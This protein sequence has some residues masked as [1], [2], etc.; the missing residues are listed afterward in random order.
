MKGSRHLALI[1][2]LLVVPTFAG[3]AAPMGEG[4]DPTRKAPV[5]PGESAAKMTVPEGFTVTLFAG[6]PDVRQPIAMAFDDRGRLWV[7][8]C[9]SYP[10]WLHPDIGKRDRILIFEDR[11]GDGHFDGR[12]VF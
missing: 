7:A 10:A 2:V 11:D 6:E 12:K 4:S 8:E 9:Y 1:L 5:P 3:D